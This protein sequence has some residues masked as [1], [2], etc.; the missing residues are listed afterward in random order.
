MPII[1]KQ[2]T[3][4]ASK[5]VWA[6]FIYIVVRDH[7]DK[8]WSFKQLDP[9]ATEEVCNDPENLLISFHKKLVSLVSWV[10][11]LTCRI[12]TF[13]DSLESRT[14]STWHKVLYTYSHNTN[15]CI[16]AATSFCI[17]YMVDNFTTI[18]FSKVILP[19]M[20]KMK[21]PTILTIYFSVQFIFAKPTTIYHT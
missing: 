6:G 3:G 12:W 13:L 15:L 1:Q 21:Y 8:S 20:D 10:L 18:K 11:C 19:A 17:M 7:V 16:F 5:V 2:R 9:E 4:P 14:L